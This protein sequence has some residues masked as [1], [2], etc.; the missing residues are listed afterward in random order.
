MI[1]V[2]ELGRAVHMAFYVWQP[3]AIVTSDCDDD[4]QNLCLA[5]RPNMAQRLGAVGDC[6]A[7]WVRAACA[8]VFE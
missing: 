4:I 3:G 6:L 1:F 2:Q 7:D 5:Q 8:F